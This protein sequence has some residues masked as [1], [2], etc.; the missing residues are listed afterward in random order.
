MY[1]ACKR[2]DVTTQVKYEIPEKLSIKRV[3][4]STRGRRA[5]RPILAR[6]L[7]RAFWPALRAQAGVPSQL[8]GSAAGGAAASTCWWQQ[9]SNIAVRRCL[10]PCS[11]SLAQ[12]SQ[13]ALAVS[14]PYNH[15]RRR[16][17]ALPWPPLRF[18]SFHG[19]LLFL[20]TVSRKSCA[21]RTERFEAR[22]SRGRTV[23]DRAKG[24]EQRLSTRCRV[25][26]TLR[27]PERDLAG[28][29]K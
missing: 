16:L 28:V 27:Q 12:A 23:F 5:R 9:S 7:G 17:S 25:E 29:N 4:L 19:T 1:D 3:Q 26:L 11:S 21:P 24:L 15:L 13:N 18:S 8:C 14:D 2:V 10:P 22:S 6:G 20:S